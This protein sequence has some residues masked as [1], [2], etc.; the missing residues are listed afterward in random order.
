MDTKHLEAVE[1]WT[2][3][4]SALAIAVAFLG[5]GLR[6]AFAVTVGALL[7]ILNAVALRR[8]GLR[9]FKRWQRPGLA[10]LLFNVKMGVLLAL[11]WAAIRYLKV[12]PIAFV[13][14]ISV[15]PV[16][17]VIVAIRNLNAGAAPAHE[18]PNG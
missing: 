2:L 14:G 6:T 5:F 3:G 17:I 18:D 9:A 1:R 8:I 16:A 13:I 12:E 11:V 15:F 7:M 4:L 10:I